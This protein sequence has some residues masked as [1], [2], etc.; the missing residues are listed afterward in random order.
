VEPEPVVDQRALP[1]L[2]RRAQ[3]AEAQPRRRELLQVLGRKE[4]RED[5]VE[6]RAEL[7]P[8]P[9]RV[10]PGPGSLNLDA[11]RQRRIT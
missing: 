2:R 4:E 8:G 3:Q 5:L 11:R 6:R 9:E 1:D 7:D 10:R